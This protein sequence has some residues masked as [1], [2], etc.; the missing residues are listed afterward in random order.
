M[1]SDDFCLLCI[2]HYSFIES[3]CFPFLHLELKPIIRLNMM[4]VNIIYELDLSVLDITE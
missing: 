3:L 1:F 4:I 2:L